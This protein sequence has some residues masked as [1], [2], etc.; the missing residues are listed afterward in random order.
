VTG[1]CSLTPAERTVIELVATGLTN[2]EVANALFLSRHTVASHL[3]S[4]YA[5]LAVRTRLEAALLVHEHRERTC[6]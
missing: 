6:A 5:K 3:K 1:Y 4:V 2:P